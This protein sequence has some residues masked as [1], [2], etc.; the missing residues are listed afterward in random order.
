MKS[1]YILYFI[2][3]IVLLGVGFL[4]IPTHSTPAASPTTIADP[5]A[6]PGIATSSAPWPAELTHLLDRL[7]ADN[8]P[9]LA[10][11]GSVMHIHQHLDV[12]VEGKPVTIPAGIGIAQGVGFSPIHVHDGTGV[13]HVESPTVETFTLGQFFDVWGV[14][15]TATCIGGYCADGTKTLKVYVNGTLYQGDPRL[16]ALAQHQEIAITYGTDK[17]APQIPAV[18]SFPAGD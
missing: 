13:I 15:F 14:K 7:K 12:F 18:F 16:L 9:A 11:E 6:L 1:N 2:G 5:S 17:E 4:L 8:L 10:M 3:A